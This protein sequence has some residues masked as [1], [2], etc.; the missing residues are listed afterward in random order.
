MHSFRRTGIGEQQGSD[1]MGAEVM[2]RAK[3]D[4]SAFLLVLVLMSALFLPALFLPA[5]ARAAEAEVKLTVTGASSELRDNIVSYIGKLSA[6]DLKSWRNTR[7][8]LNDNVR[9]A[10]QSM[11]YYRGDY[12]IEHSDMAVSIVVSPGQPVR[13]RKLLLQFR[14][15]AGNDIAFTA[16]REH[17][18]INEGDVFHHGK[19]ETLKNAVQNLASEHGYFD[20][21]W[22][23]HE[24][25]VDPQAGVADI[26]LVFDSG[27]RYRFGAVSFHGAKGQPQTIVDDDLLQRFLPFVVGDPYD[28][29]K[30]I[31]LNRSLLNS[32]YF[33]DVRVRVQRDAPAA[34]ATREQLAAD[35]LAVEGEAEQPA[36][37][38]KAPAA[39]ADAEPAAAAAK[40]LEVPI[41]IQI[42]ADKRNNMDFGIGYSTDI[43]ERISA[44]WQRPLVNTKGHGIEVN[45]ELS[46]VRSTFDAKYT[47]PLTHPIEDILQY[48]YGVKREEVE[49]DV[50][51]WNT[52]LGMQRLI[53]HESGWQR[54]YSLRWNRDTTE[55]PI[56][57]DSG[58]PDVLGPIIGTETVK[59]DLVLPGVSLDRTRLKGTAL[60][61]VWGDR[62][63]YQAEVASKNVLSDASLISLR[64]GMRF[65]RTFDGVHQIILRGDAGTVLTNDFDAVP[66]SMRFFAG[67]DQSV[68]GYG[69]KSI[70]PRDENGV[71]V[72]AR[73]LLTG[74]VEYDY[75]FISRWRTAIFV[76]SGDAFDEIGEESFKIGSGVGIRWVSPVGPIRLDFAWAVSEEDRP[77]RIHFSMGPNL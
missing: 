66:Q 17:M 48:F 69:Y 46:P 27:G 10:L 4:R 59:T 7:V 1:G 44:K 16:L 31:K 25:S 23:Q 52:V 54:T 58:V 56:R 61:P 45:A 5:Q 26:A 14:G 11:G 63:F 62:Q 42:A 36:G 50:V 28:A 21:E 38:V 40:E 51:N 35:K 18:A 39:T 76:D 19:Y 24:V 29:D 20:A 65:L 53:K 12:Q 77:F 15:E 68:R 33:S 71:A 70:S 73:N 57:A 43:K 2:R 32:R 64:A 3:A 74:S 13:V 55:T 22:L 47:I 34:D 75:E 37:E 30:V 8:R 9:E 6:D 72:G 41:D 67:G 60:D 49:D